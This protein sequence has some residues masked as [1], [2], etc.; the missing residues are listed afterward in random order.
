MR[1]TRAIA[2]MALAASLTA[3]MDN[4]LGPATGGNGSTGGP[5]TCTYMCTDLAINPIGQ[6]VLVGD[7]MLLNG[8]TDRVNNAS[9][10]WTVVSDNAVLKSGATTGKTLTTL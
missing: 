1:H 7:T 8:F 5:Y 2:L 10:E 6:N 4:F 3:C 9:I